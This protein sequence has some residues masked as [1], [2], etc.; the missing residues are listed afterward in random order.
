MAS[1]REV[2]VVINGEEYVSKAAKEAEVGM[3]GFAGFMERLKDKLIPVVDVTKLVEFA[4]RALSAAFNA[5][6]Q[7]VLDS[8]GSYDAYTTALAKLRAQSQLTGVPMDQMNALVEKA[9]K[10]F[11]L[12]TIAAIDV[13]AAVAKFA[14]AAGDS[15]KASGLMASALELGAASGMNATQVAEGLSSALA[16]NDEWLNRLG[17]SNPSVIW[18]KYRVA[19]GLAKDQMDDT[20]KALAVMTAIMDAGNTVTGVYAD[21][22]ASGAGQQEKLNNRLDE[23]KVAFGTALQPLRIFIVQGLTALINVVGPVVTALG[24]LASGVLNMVVAPF[25]LAYSGVGS[26]ME[27]VGKLTGNRELEKWGRNASQEFARFTDDLGRWLGVARPATETTQAMGRA[28]ELAAVKIVAN[29]EATEKQTAATKRA[30][31]EHEA[32]TVVLGMTQGAV[33]R[34]AQAAKDQL[35]PKPAQDFGA[36]MDAIRANADALIAKFPPITAGTQDAADNTRKAATNTKDMA[37]EVEL[38]ARGALD[39]ATSFGVIDENASRSLQSAINIASAIGNLAKSGFS[40]AGVTGVIGGVA[41]LVN[42]MMAGDAERRRLLSQNNQRLE[43]LRDE[44]GNLNLNVTGEDLTKA[45]GFLS[46]WNNPGGVKVTDLGAFYA[47]LRRSGLSVQDLFRIADELGINIKTKDGGL[48]TF[49]LPQLLERIRTIEPGQFGQSFAEQLRATTAGFGVRGTDEL[50]QIGALGNLGGQFSSALRGVIDINDIAGTRARL[51]ALFERLNNGGV[52][53]AEL[54]GLTGSQF[55]DFITD[56]IGRIDRL[57]PGGSGA[58]SSDTPAPAPT[59]TTP[60]ESEADR[61]KRERREA[62]Q[63]MLDEIEI[64]RLNAEDRLDYLRRQPVT[65]EIKN[66]IAMVE[67]LIRDLD[68]QERALRRRFKRE[69]LTGE[70]GP[71]PTPTTGSTPPPA[72]GS[73]VVGG[74]Q[75]PTATVQDVIKAMDTSLSNILTV[76][77][78]LHERI[79]AATESSAVSLQ[80]ID[81]KMDELIAVTA[82]SI[83]ATDA[84]LEAMRRMAA[85]ERGE[86]PSFG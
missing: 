38:F 64:N 67:Q 22:M 33:E 37:R 63:K 18:E 1:K 8:I 56:I 27:V 15:S 49:A 35:P 55:L 12:G 25:K 21:R 65:Q 19:N 68:D 46:R 6:K 58:P 78:T 81:G 52:S 43:E 51:A 30:K 69:D 75:V 80:S 11:G 42:S 73:I 26:V 48:N 20:T 10:E 24:Y 72:T 31:S 77:T 7:F 36:A 29:A 74:S 76:H 57:Q 71:M 53:A 45:E 59:P 62:R 70:Y 54:G 9:R 85:L 50:G 44:I 47:D 84:K 13:T 41:A 66:Q 4:V 32:L 14:T 2:T 86:R 3:T 28:H 39:A 23:A 79:A 16:G 40:F 60:V 61:I 83:D 17:L 82:G 5:A 34:L